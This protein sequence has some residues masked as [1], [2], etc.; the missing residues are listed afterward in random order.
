[1][2]ATGGTDTVYLGVMPHFGNFVRWRR[3]AAGL[4][5]RDFAKA[6]GVDAKTV[7]NIE[8]RETPEG[9]DDITLA[10]LA[11]WL[12]TPVELLV[13]DWVRIVETAA[14]TVWVPLPRT[15][16]DRIAARAAEDGYTDVARYIIRVMTPKEW[17][18]KGGPDADDAGASSP[19]LP[20]E[21]GETSEAPTGAT[22]RGRPPAQA[23]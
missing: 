9:T 4:K 20:S 21:P 17:V 14:D 3:A 11:D 12:Q 6:L 18:F 10:R 7:T 19:R 1:M 2:T 8:R 13:T 5:K 16:Y 23:R 15:D 22:K